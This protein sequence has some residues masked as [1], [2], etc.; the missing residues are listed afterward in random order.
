MADAKPTAET[1]TAERKAPEVEIPDSG[2]REAPIR[3]GKDGRSAAAPAQPENRPENQSRLRLAAKMAIGLVVVI[4]LGIGVLWGIRR[5][6]YGKTH[7]STDDAYVTGNLVNIS[8][9]ISG[10]LDSLN[11]D[12]GSVVKKGQLIA[13]LGANSATATLRQ[14]QAA[15]DAALS[16]IPQAEKSLSYQQATT[17]AAIR[18]AE[19]AIAGQRAK[20]SG[21]QQQVTLTTATF[22][23]QVDQAQS[24]VG[25]AEAQAAKAQAD[26]LTAI[27]ALDNYRQGVQTAQRS[28]RAQ[29]DRIRAA[30]AEADRAGKEETRYKQLLA[31]DAVSAQQYDTVRAQAL[32]A[33]AQLSAVQDEADQ[34][35]S[36]VAQ[37]QKSVVQAEAQVKAAEQA[38]AAARKQIDVARAGLKLAR[39]NSTQVG[40]QQTNVLSSVEQAG[41]DR[42]DLASAVAGREQTA[43]KQDQITTA[44]AQAAEAKQALVNA[45]INLNHTFI[46]APDDGTIVKKTANVGAS[47][48]PGQPIVTMTQGGSVWVTANY[49]ETQMQDVRAGQPAEV[50]VDSLPGRLFQGRVESI[51]EVTG[52]ATSLLPPDNAT[53]NFTKVVQRI[54]VRIA[55]IPARDNDDPRYAR[56]GDIH[57]L[58]QGM[59]VTATIDTGASR[60]GSR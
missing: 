14:A 20:T 54:P 10:T 60:K 56:A 22:R 35:N 13:R 27:A 1:T 45:Q 2:A 46:Y 33:G 42:A 48:A 40:I 9:S 53:G 7:V 30:Q 29:A 38:A 25:A 44:K 57:N 52:A 43:L 49:K 59:S 16:Q 26:V 34:A 17:E 5:W 31:E 47:L 23:N 11:V 3:N 21:A 39:A 18:K 55:L 41:Q 6:D 37:A 51:N 50:E 58:R 36:Q 15:Y 32:S 28:A 19:A 12:E 8:P 4:L 24:Q